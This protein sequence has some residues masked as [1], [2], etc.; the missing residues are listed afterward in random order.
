MNDA[1]VKEFETKLPAALKPGCEV[2][3]WKEDRG[4]GFVMK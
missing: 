3:F 1:E 4:I 2:L